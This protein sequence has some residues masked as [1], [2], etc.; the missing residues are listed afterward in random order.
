MDNYNGENGVW[1]T[2][3]GRKVFIKNGQSLQ[4]A[5][6]ESGKF[7]DLKSTSS[8]SEN[9]TDTSYQGKEFNKAYG[10]DST[11]DQMHSQLSK[12]APN[13][14][15]DSEVKETLQQIERVKNNPNANVNIYRAT[16]GDTINEGD[17]IFLSR[18]QAERWTKTHFG[19]PKPGFKVLEEQTE[20]RNVDWTGKNL[21]FVLRREK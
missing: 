16:P 9:K 18:A 20:A 15:N 5:M 1:R 4:S 19:T 21:E 7:D 14:V 6:A 13:T 2:I 12:L 11:V 8:S 10:R 3:S 17:W